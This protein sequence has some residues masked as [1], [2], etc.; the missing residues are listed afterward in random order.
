MQ[1]RRREPGPRRRPPTIGGER[2]APN[3]DRPG[4]ARPI[5]RITRGPRRESPPPLGDFGEA[6]LT[7]SLDGDRD[8]ERGDGGTVAIRLL[9]AEPRFAACGAP[10]AGGTRRTGRFT[11]RSAPEAGSARRTGRFA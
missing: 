4:A 11:A 8:A 2:E 3:R 1:R 7:V 9:E 5:R 10:E 6:I